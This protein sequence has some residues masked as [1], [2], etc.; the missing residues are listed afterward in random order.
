MPVKKYGQ[1][2][3]KIKQAVNA[4]IDFLVKKGK[5]PEQARAILLGMKANGQL[6]L[7]AME[8]DTA[9]GLLQSSTAK[10][11]FQS[12]LSDAQPFLDKL[13]TEKQ[14]RAF[15][16]NRML[17]ALPE[18]AKARGSK[19]QIGEVTARATSL[20]EGMSEQT[21]Q[22]LEGLYEVFGEDNTEPLMLAME[23]IMSGDDKFKSECVG[24]FSEEE[25]D[26]IAYQIM[27]ARNGRV[28]EVQDDNQPKNAVTAG[29]DP[30]AFVKRY[31]SQRGLAE[32]EEKAR[33][34]AKTNAKGRTSDE[35][36]IHAGGSLIWATAAKSIT[37]YLNI[38]GGL[39][40]SK[41]CAQKDKDGNWRVLFC[42][43]EVM[44]RWRCVGVTIQNGYDYDECLTE[45]RD[46]ES[47]FVE[48]WPTREPL[49]INCDAK[50]NSTR[51]SDPLYKRVKL[52]NQDR[53]VKPVAITEHKG[54]PLK[55][56]CVQNN[57]QS[58]THHRLVA[59]YIYHYGFDF[60]QHPLIRKYLD[61]KEGQ[62]FEEH[63]PSSIVKIC[64]T[65]QCE[66]GS[67]G[68]NI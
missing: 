1:L 67:G 38:K 23:A 24:N 42:G 33:A 30:R 60:S 57:E 56:F 39:G 6:G 26:E 20:V 58:I 45:L 59:I 11:L 55:T 35:N 53:Y 49:V 40:H 2:E 4:E 43:E 28:D 51:N 29:M 12:A 5:S 17:A 22:Q 66:I 8:N 7:G 36:S 18:K 13:P 65:A 62:S 14:K 54:Q 15:W 27:L 19:R 44:K 46:C 48:L 50:R 61:L 16:T 68:R 52:A 9:F 3:G 41:C 32:L 21:K 47:L 34:E 37:D 64:R 63:E 25:A 31:G 10:Q